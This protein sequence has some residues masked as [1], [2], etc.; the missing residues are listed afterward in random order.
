[1]QAPTIPADTYIADETYHALKEALAP[2]V[3]VPPERCGCDA[4]TFIVE[5][6]GEIGDIWPRSVWTMRKR[7]KSLPP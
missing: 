7:P 4:A 3:T 6:L 2:F 5:T 1:M